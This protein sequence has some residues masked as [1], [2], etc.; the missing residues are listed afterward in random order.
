MAMLFLF[1]DGFGIGEQDTAKNPVYSANAPNIGRIFDTFRLFPT[2]ATLGVPGLPQS[3]TGQTAIFTG[4]NAPA[5]IGR[6]LSGQP[7]ASLRNIIIGNN[8][9]KA[10]T[11]IGLRVTNANV[12]RDEYLQRMLDPEERKYRPSV[13][14]VMTMSAGVPFRNVKEFNDG[15][16][17]YHDITGQILAEYGYDAIVITPE[18][19]AQRLY[20]ISRNYDFTLFEHFLPDIIGHTGDMEKALAEINLLD[21]FLGHILEAFDLNEDI[22]FIASDHGNIE[23]MSVKTHT[24]NRVPTLIGGRIPGDIGIRIGTLMDIMP[25]VLNI[26][27]KKS[28]PV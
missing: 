19:A 24:C 15:L 25:A 3:A 4:V 6:H 18:E 5:L 17:V 23:D 16:G 12:Y 27:S 9:F 21:T 26:L 2:D 8:L 10:L 20:K 14:S 7:T 13:T 22:V 11:G 28:L 1:I